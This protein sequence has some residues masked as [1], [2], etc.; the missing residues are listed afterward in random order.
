MSGIVAG[1]AISVAAAGAKATQSFSQASKQ[2]KSARGK[3]FAEMGIYAKGIDP[4][5]GETDYGA[6][7]SRMIEYTDPATGETKLVP[8]AFAGL[9]AARENQQ[10]ME[11]AQAERQ[12][13]LSSIGDQY[14]TMAQQGLPDAVERGM[15]QN[16]QQ[17][18]S[19]LL[20]GL[21][22]SRGGLRGVSGVANQQN[23]AYQNLAMM[24]AQA[25]QQA[26]RDYL[27][28]QD[29]AA[30]Q[31]YAMEADQLAL[32]NALA[33]QQLGIYNQ[34]QGQINALYGAAQQ[35]MNQGWNTIGDLAGSLGYG[36]ATG[37]IDVPS[38]GGGKGT[39]V[40]PTGSLYN[41][42]GTGGYGNPTFG[43]QLAGNN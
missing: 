17:G 29:Y 4:D 22:A 43:Q 34:G 6:D 16:I 13:A 23:Q 8:Q 35:N 26:Q 41:G 40:T 19:Q 20:R 5:T 32:N 11:L 39:G 30:Q 3:Q 18:T 42:F 7:K 36:I 27:Q 1:L 2:R 24:D 10:N 38:F 9:V 33:E 37:G 15:Q 28:F 25:R 12:A 14:L 21:Q 31:N